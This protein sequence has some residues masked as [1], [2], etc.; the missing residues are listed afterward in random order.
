MKHLVKCLVCGKEFET[1]RTD[2]VCCS[3]ACRQRKYRAAREAERLGNL[4]CEIRMAT[5]QPRPPKPATV[6]NIADSITAIKGEL[7]ALRFYA[8]SCPPSIRPNIIA[9]CDGVDVA[10]KETG[11]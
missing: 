7:T 11:L 6:N 2:A 9:F 1:T 5:P 4:L 3:P 10:L 8:R